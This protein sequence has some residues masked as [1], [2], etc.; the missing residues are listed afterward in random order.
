MRY[1]LPFLIITSF[2]SA[3]A[4][5]GDNYTLPVDGKSD[6]F[7]YMSQPFIEDGSHKL[8]MFSTNEN[9]LLIYNLEERKIERKVIYDKQ[10][11]NKLTNMYMHGSLKY[12]NQ[13]SIFYYD[14][15]IGRGVLSDIEGNVYHRFAI[16]NGIYGYGSLK[17][18]K[19]MGYKNGKAYMQAWLNT[20]G[21]NAVK[22]Y[23]SAPNKIAII[24]ITDGSVEEVLFD[25]PAVYK[26]RDLSQILKDLDIVYNPHTD[27]FVIS[28]PFSHYLFETDFKGYTKKHLAKSD[29]VQ[30]AVDME[31][32][33]A[34]ISATSLVSYTDWISDKY[35]NLVFDPQSG[36]YF[37]LARKHISEDNFSGRDF[38]TEKEVLIFDKNLKHVKTI[39]HLGGVWLYHF[40]IGDYIYWNKNM[41]IHN[42]DAGNEDTFFFERIKF[43]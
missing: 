5:Q 12:I 17:L 20:V 26:D 38:T 31:D 42:L 6:L 37:R 25:F 10:G 35:E 33:K 3:K 7:N 30:E 43:K 36:Y 24:D 41:S 15:Q 21:K 13:D 19:T 16:N 34:R 18:R 1:I 22:D 28:F 9:A 14:V 29:L 40:V 11:P 23:K 32:Y 4:Q 2:F 27:K 39:E 8:A